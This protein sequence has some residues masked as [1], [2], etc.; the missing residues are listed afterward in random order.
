[1][2]ANFIYGLITGAGA[3]VLVFIY[4]NAITADKVD[5]AEDR[6]RDGAG[7]ARGLVARIKAFFGK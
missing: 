4:L 5:R 3:S 7:K 6:I 2:M 1:M